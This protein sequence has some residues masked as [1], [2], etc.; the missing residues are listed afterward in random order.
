M[1]RILYAVLPTIL[2]FIGG[3]AS[4][5]LNGSANAQAQKADESN[6]VQELVR[7]RALEIVSKDG[8]VVGSFSGFEKQSEGAVLQ[9]GYEAD[10]PGVRGIER[11]GGIS[12]SGRAFESFL[13]LREPGYKN[14][15]RLNTGNMSIESSRDDT[16][17]GLRDRIQIAPD[18]LGVSTD[19]RGV[20]WLGRGRN[21]TD[22]SYTELELSGPSTSLTQPARIRL[23]VPADKSKSAEL[24]FLH[25]NGKVIKAFSEK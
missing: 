24:Q 1:N 21:A 15:S 11:F 14:Y 7:T 17:F 20:F 22:P 3:C 23:F 16:E 12:L 18:G 8:K 13:E 6:R 25:E 19:G 5:M 9:L 10:V 2:G 4:Q